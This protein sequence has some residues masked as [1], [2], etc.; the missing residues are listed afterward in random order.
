MPPPYVKTI[1][2][3]IY[4]YYAKL[5]I[6]RSAGF[7]GNYKFIT[8]TF[9]KLKRGEIKISDYDRE[10]FKQM[11]EP[12]TKC[13][14]CGCDG[15]LT[16]EHIIPLELS[17]PPGPHNVVFVCKK[18]NSS[19]GADDLIEWWQNKL[20]KKLDELPRIPA[21]IYLK[22]C[23]DAHK[24]NH[25]LQS[26]CNDLKYLWPFGKSKVHGRKK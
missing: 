24:M 3:V 1:E 18:C 19:K 23:Y 7:E 26:L 14:F 17:G 2:D 22:L 16:K 8:Y 11:E 5:V 6:A 9:K 12:Q 20:G 21:A 13:Q 4:Y 15:P 10:I 25:T